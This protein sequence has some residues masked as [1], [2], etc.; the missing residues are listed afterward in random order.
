MRSIRWRRILSSLWLEFW[1]PL[2]LLGA[3]LWFSGNEATNYLLSRPFTTDD[4]LKLLAD[5]PTQIN[6]SIASLS[7]TATINQSKG[8]TKVEAIAPD[9]KIEFVL[10]T[11][12]V[13]QV[14]SA[15]ATKL[16]ISRE[17]VRKLTRYVL[18]PT[19]RR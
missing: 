2:P 18:I 7:I 11:T 13:R 10:S 1:L 3:L 14:E 17:D 6:L 5:P 16:T 8:L 12:D 19:E 4:A 15:I 9:R